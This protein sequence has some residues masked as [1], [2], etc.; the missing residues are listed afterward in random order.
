MKRL[1]YVVICLLCVSY[2]ALRN[3]V[4]ALGRI[5][6]LLLDLMGHVKVVEIGDGATD[7]DWNKGGGLKRNIA[8][9]LERLRANVSDQHGFKTFYYGI[10]TIRTK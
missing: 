2:S 4:Y 10:G 6:V 5:D 1:I 8:I 9:T 3:T 7:Y